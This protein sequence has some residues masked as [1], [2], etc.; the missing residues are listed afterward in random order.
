[1]IYDVHTNLPARGPAYTNLSARSPTLRT[2]PSVVQHMLF[3]SFGLSSILTKVKK[4]F[5]A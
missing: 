2:Y 3:T 1:M 5:L 4:W